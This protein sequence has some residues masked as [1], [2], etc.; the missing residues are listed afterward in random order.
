MQTFL[1]L[2]YVVPVMLAILLWGYAIF[3]LWYL[4]REL[5]K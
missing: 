5:R 4:S 3:I 2:F 1:L